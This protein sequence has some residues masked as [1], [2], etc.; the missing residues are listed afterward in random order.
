MTTKVCP[1]CNPNIR[2]RIVAEHGSVFAVSDIYPVTDGHLLIL[3]K[4]HISDWFSLTEEERQ[5]A[6]KLILC[7]REKLLIDDPTI[8][9]FNIGVNC[10]ASAGQT[11]FHVH[12]HLIPR[13]DGDVDDPRG[14]VRGVIPHKQKY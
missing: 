12:I 6:E 10:G 14:G 3:P 5:D 9:G 2:S 4:R 1:F 13:R 8:T 11:I 7:M